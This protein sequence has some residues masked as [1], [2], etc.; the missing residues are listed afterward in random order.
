MSDITRKKGKKKSKSAGR[1]G[2][3]ER[4]TRLSRFSIILFLLSVVI[5]GAYSYNR[6][7]TVDG[8]APVITIDNP[9]IEV[10]IHDPEE[11]LLEG[12]TAEDRKDGD[13]SDSILV[14]SLSSFVSQ[15][16]RLVNYAAFDSDNHVSHASR[17]IVY[18]DY[19]EPRFHLSEPLIFRLNYSNIMDGLT[20]TDCLDGDVTSLIKVVPEEEFTVEKAGLYDVVF[21][22]S[23]SAGDLR[24]FSTKVEIY[25]NTVS[26][27]PQFTLSDYLVYV[28]K[29]A[30]FDP[31]AYLQTVTISGKTY[32]IVQGYGNYYSDYVD[33]GTERTVGTS[34]ITVENPVRT[35]QSGSYTVYYRISVETRNQETLT[36]KCP[37]I[38]IVRE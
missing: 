13:V 18:R 16:T 19:T 17:K 35:D 3:W 37:L 34:M 5:F 4:Q 20:A 10:S 23:N 26:R 31:Y 32:Q 30:A 38:V 36:G 27:G 1:P 21:Q 25:D 7:T 2:L 9:Q 11:K 14:E 22:V 12:I 28:D 33:P 29:G 8:S 6:S 15:N 24:S